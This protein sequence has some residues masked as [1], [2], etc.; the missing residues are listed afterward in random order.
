MPQKAGCAGSNK[1][2]DVQKTEI[3]TNG[4]T[5]ISKQLSYDGD[6][7]PCQVWIQLDKAFFHVKVQKP[8][9]WPTDK[10][11]DGITPILKAT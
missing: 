7:S 10:K 6:L 11:T 8:K 9:C 2:S 1:F 5:Q 3:W 4:I